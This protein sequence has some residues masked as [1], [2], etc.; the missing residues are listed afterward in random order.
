MAEE[1][2]SGFLCHFDGLDARGIDRKK[3]YTLTCCYKG[4]TKMPT[5]IRAY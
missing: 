5:T 4:L 1:D 2:T 3:R